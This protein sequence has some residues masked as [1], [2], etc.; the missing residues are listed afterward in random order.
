MPDRG[1]TTVRRQPSNTPLQALVL[2]NDRAFF[3]FAQ[4]LA[5]RV[6]D[7]LRL[8]VGRPR[9]PGWFLGSHGEST[10]AHL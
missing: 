7:E 5:G 10:I 4:A 2:L 1:S 8:A 3:E 9:A 6:L